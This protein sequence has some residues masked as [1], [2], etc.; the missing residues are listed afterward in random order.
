MPSTMGKTCSTAAAAEGILGTGSEGTMTAKILASSGMLPSALCSSKQGK[1]DSSPGARSTP[2]WPPSKISW[3]QGTLPMAQEGDS[4][5]LVD[6]EAH[7]GEEE[8][9]MAKSDPR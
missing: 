2:Y 3:P 4:V 9:S 1:E 7:K 8:E 6:T 5:D